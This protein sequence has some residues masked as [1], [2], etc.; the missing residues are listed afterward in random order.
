M[1]DSFLVFLDARH[2]DCLDWRTD[3]RYLD[4]PTGNAAKSGQA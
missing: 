1:L 3:Q 2:G 4:L